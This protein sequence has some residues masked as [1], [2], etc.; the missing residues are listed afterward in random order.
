MTIIVTLICILYTIIVGM[1]AFRFGYHAGVKD[2]ESQVND[3][4][5]QN[6]VQVP[7]DQ[8]EKLIEQLG[9]VDSTHHRQQHG[10]GGR[11]YL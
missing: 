1:L 3:W 8:A 4:L 7:S 10:L 2:A 11:G 5:K 6:V 9:Q